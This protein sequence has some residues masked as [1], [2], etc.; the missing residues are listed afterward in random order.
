MVCINGYICAFYDDCLFTF[1]LNRSTSFSKRVLV[2]LFGLHYKLFGSVTHV[3]FKSFL[4]IDKL[5]IV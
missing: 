1:C 5:F 2:H 4:S 3:H